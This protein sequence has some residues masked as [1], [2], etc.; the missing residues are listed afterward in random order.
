MVSGS[1]VI[2]VVGRVLT[3][4]ARGALYVAPTVPG[5][6]HLIA[7][8]ECATQI[9]EVVDAGPKFVQ[10]YDWAHFPSEYVI[11]QWEKA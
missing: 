4:F 8:E 7:G 11:E 2:G 10:I 3:M 9:Q 6:Y 5:P 1:S